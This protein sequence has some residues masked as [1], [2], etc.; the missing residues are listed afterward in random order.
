MAKL[1]PN[2]KGGAPFLFFGEKYRL[3]VLALSLL[4]WYS[5]Q[6]EKRCNCLKLLTFKDEP[7]AG[8]L[9]VAALGILPLTFCAYFV[10]GLQT[11][12]SM[13]TATKAMAV[14]GIMH[15]VC[16]YALN[17]RANAIEAFV[18]PL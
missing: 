6:K 8:L 5:M 12:L 13:S 2:P 16:L 18:K 9:F 14:V 7:Y 1:V 17:V 3:K 15:V 10:L 4:K 11:A